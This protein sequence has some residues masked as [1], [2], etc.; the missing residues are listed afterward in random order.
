MMWITRK[1]AKEVNSAV[2]IISLFSGGSV[3]P[4]GSVLPDLS[5]SSF[6]SSDINEIMK[7]M[8]MIVIIMSA[9]A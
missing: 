1:S 4:A 6:C 2:I 5:V 8:A 3:Q 7:G 9:T